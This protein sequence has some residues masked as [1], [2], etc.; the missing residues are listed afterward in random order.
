MSEPKLRENQEALLAEVRR[1]W[2]ASPELRLLQ[3]LKNAIDTPEGKRLDATR[4][5]YYEDDALRE[6]LQE[7]LKKWAR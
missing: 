6:R 3:L 2:A 1:A 5:F 7:W 4:V